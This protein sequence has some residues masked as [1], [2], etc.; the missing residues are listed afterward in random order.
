M[1]FFDQASFLNLP[2]IQPSHNP[3]IKPDFKTAN[4]PV[5]R[6][7]KNQATLKM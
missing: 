7:L 4:K 2:V 1:N 3:L 6:M 5:K